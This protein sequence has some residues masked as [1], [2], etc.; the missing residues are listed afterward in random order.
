MASN[1]PIKSHPSLKIIQ[2]EKL[3][4]IQ[5]CAQSANQI[6]RHT[7]TIIQS[8]SFEPFEMA[9]ENIDRKQ[10]TRIGIKVDFKS[11]LKAVMQSLANCQACTLHTCQI[12]L[13]MGENLR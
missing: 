12:S 5:Y 2:S 9:P 1:Q 8:E 11:S 7:P 3:S 10:W 6:R 4:E 13:K